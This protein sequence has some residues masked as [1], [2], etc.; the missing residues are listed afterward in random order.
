M[1]KVLEFFADTDGRM[2]MSR[3]LCFLS[4]IPASV[5]LVRINSAEA[6]GWYVGAYVAGYVGGKFGERRDN[7]VGDK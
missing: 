1:G 2:S 4:F 3:L 7:A 6:L 5:A